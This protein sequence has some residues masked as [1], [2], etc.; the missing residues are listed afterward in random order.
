M[1]NLLPGESV[2]DGDVFI[3]APEPSR[4]SWVVQGPFGD[5]AVNLEH[6]VFGQR[7]VCQLRDP[8]HRRVVVQDHSLAAVPRRPS[9]PQHLFRDLPCRGGSF[10]LTRRD[11]FLDE[12]VDVVLISRLA[13]GDL[14]RHLHLAAE[15]QVNL[16][17]SLRD[18]I[19]GDVIEGLPVLVDEG[20]H[21]AGGLPLELGQE[22]VLFAREPTGGLAVLQLVPVEIS[23]LEE[24]PRSLL[25]DLQEVELLGFE[26]LIQLWRYRWLPHVSPYARQGL[27]TSLLLLSLRLVVHRLAGLGQGHY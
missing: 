9:G 24:S 16:M 1:Q 18:G 11:G 25:D 13:I 14:F 3:G 27:P 6:E 2:V 12:R 19:D 17:Q 26:E 5:K 21:L 7:L 22:P 8:L 10:Q 4:R 20:H 23:P 15:P